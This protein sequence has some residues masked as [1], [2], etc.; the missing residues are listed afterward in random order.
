MNPSIKKYNN[1]LSLLQTPNELEIK[2]SKLFEEEFN[3]LYEDILIKS[4]KEFL[5]SLLFN[6]KFSI[7]D[8]NNFIFKNFKKKN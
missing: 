1:F 2:I 5:E 6:S 7:E 8:Q 3:E 4:D